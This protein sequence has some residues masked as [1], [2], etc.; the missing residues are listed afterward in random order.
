MKANSKAAWYAGL[1]H[2]TLLAICLMLFPV[3]SQAK[4]KATH[5]FE[6]KDLVTTTD[7]VEYAAIH[8][9]DIHD[10]FFSLRPYEGTK[11]C[12]MCHESEG[13]EMLTTG[14]FKWEGYSDRIVGLEG[15]SH[16]KN[17]LINNFCVAVPTNEPRCTQCHAGYGYKDAGYDFN[18][19]EN[20]DC[21]VCHDQSGTYKKG[22]T[23]GGWPDP[24]V[25]LETVVRSITVGKEPTRKAC[26]SCHSH[27]GGGDNVKHGDLSSDMVATTREYDVHMGVDGGNMTC[28]ACHGANHDPE[29]GEV[30]HG[31]AGMS[32][33]SVN[34]G[35]MKQ[36]GDCHGSMNRIH[37][38]TSVEP[39]IAEGLHGNL[40]CQVCH[41]PAIARKI[42]TKT[43]WYWSD[44]GQNVS[45]IPVDPVT[46]RP[47][48]DKKKGTFVWS[49]N[50]R[51]TLRYAN[52]KWNRPVIGFSDTYSAIPIDL[53]S[54]VGDYTD[55]KAKI[56][57]FKLMKGNQPVDP[58]TK[59]ILVPHLFGKISGPNPYWG[60]F[61]WTLA[62]EDGA[63]YTGQDF[64][65]T[66]SFEPTT[67]L[68]SVNHEIAPKEMALG[69]G[70]NCGDCHGSSQVDWQALG[71]SDDPF[72]GGT[73][74][75]AM[76]EQAASVDWVPPLRLDVGLQ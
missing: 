2:L 62:S 63:N 21:L 9:V 67:M 3:I 71:W 72:N 59:T 40:A 28:T 11:S 52:G 53:G 47:T 37:A 68:L 58:I 12:L 70:S 41:I 65:G 13:L 17:D 32:L 42:S 55:P 61:D 31:I 23:T 56:Y 64:S 24:S 16:G 18:N 27:A 20:V 5:G 75:I 44:A 33:H 14:H 7:F 49:L 48:Y 19:P 46:G 15:Q 45:P 66:H 35:E 1:S 29:T 60:V 4:A 50:V 22:L 38:G 54:P 51:P 36:C 6:K 69:M 57:P 10:L 25:N 8:E 43:E 34:E 30:N 73:R 26:I 39:M 74:T 76:P